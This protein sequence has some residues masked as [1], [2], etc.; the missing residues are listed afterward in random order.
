MNVM[1]HI[2]AIPLFEGLPKGQHEALA[3][4]AVNRSYKKDETILNDTFT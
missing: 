3:G 1:D 4:V 2:S